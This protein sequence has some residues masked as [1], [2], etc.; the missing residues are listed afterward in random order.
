[1]K[2]LLTA[3]ALTLA[4]N[5]GILLSACAVAHAADT[6]AEAPAEDPGKTVPV[7][8]KNWKQ[9]VEDSDKPVLIDFWATWCGP[10]MK[11][12][13][14]V[15]ALSKEMTNVKFAKVNLDDSQDIADK[16]NVVIIPYLMVMYHG[17]KI[18]EYKEG[19]MEPDQL[20]KFVTDAVSKAK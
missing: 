15:A 10:C 17:K 11:L 19:Y 7:N 13:P 18:A 14:N 6:P 16:F 3:A 1:M 4:L 9:E 8:S 12:G 2:H 20:K 5:G